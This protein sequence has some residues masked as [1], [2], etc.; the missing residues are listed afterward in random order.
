MTVDLSL[1]TDV[2]LPYAHTALD[3]LRPLGGLV[4][5][6]EHWSAVDLGRLA[7]R[8][9]AGAAG[10]L[11]LAARFDPANRWFLRLALTE[12]VE[13]WL[14][15]WTPGQGTRPHD[16]GG[17][18]GAFTVLRGELT[19]TWRDGPVQARRAAK[20]RGHGSAFGPERVHTVANTGSTDAVS[21]HAY[22][23]PLLPLGTDVTLEDPPG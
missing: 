7:R 20:A 19:E 14:L 8:V 4:A 15:T 1:A 18:S 12:Q 5:P 17:A 11:H 16:H 6:R 13:V 10:E 3:A 22:S 21:V 23:P 2:R 9:A